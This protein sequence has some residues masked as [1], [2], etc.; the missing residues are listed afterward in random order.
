VL[1]CE[2]EN[3]GPS[4]QTFSSPN[5]LAGGYMDHEGDDFDFTERTGVSNCEMPAYICTRFPDAEVNSSNVAVC[6]DSLKL[7]MWKCENDNQIKH[8]GYGAESER[9]YNLH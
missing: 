2:H 3:Q 5:A 7:T 4:P 9:M 8:V 6:G 1:E